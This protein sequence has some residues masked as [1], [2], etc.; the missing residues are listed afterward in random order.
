MSQMANLLQARSETLSVFTLGFFKNRYALG[1]ILL[2]MGILLSFMYLPL[3]GTYLHMMPIVWQDWMMV[4]G[5]T[6]AVFIFEEGRKAE[7]PQR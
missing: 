4:I 6:L 7:I 1:A 3:L 2:S 5:T